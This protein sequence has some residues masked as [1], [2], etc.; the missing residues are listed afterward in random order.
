M[1]PPPIPVR[2]QISL[3]LI[4][5]QLHISLKSQSE[6]GEEKAYLSGEAKGCLAGVNVVGAAV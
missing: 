3:V 4:K 6:V 1:D 5:R 2:M